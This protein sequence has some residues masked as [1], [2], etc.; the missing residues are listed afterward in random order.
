MLQI[1]LE[2]NSIWQH[3]KAL[4]TVTSNTDSEQYKDN[5]MKSIVWFQVISTIWFATSH[6][7]PM[8]CYKP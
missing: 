2:F 4:S 1:F 8:V 7:N 3:K 6:I 5:N